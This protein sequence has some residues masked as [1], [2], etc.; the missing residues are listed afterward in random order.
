MSHVKPQVL[1]CACVPSAFELGGG[2]FGDVNGLL[3]SS[4]Q[5]D[6]SLLDDLPDVFD[7]VLFILQTRGLRHN[8]VLNSY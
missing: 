4:A 1:G 7:P 6:R 3:Q 8:T 5:V 2:G